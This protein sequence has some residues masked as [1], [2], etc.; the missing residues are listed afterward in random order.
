MPAELSFRSPFDWP[1]LLAFFRYRAIIGVEEVTDTSYRRTV[2]LC[3]GEQKISGWLCA[4]MAP[5][6][7]ALH[8]EWSPSLAPARAEIIQRVRQLFDLDA[9]PA[10]VQA[11]LGKLAQPFPG[12][13][14]PGAFDGMETTVR[15]ILGQQVT[16]AAASTLAGRVAT[17]LGT[18]IATP[19]PALTQVF[20][21]TT[22]LAIATEDE[23]G[24][25]GIVR[26]RV[27]AIKALAQGSLAGDVLLAPHEDVTAT[28][29][30]LKAVRGIGDWTAHYLAMR[31]LG[32]RDAFP[33]ADYGVMKALGVTTPK[34]AQTRAEAWRPYRAYAVMCLW[35]ALAEGR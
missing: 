25:L 1:R 6:G 31:V 21:V 2:E 11:V 12:V 14:V 27:A 22:R 8:L 16:V 33:A 18:P 13:R 20:P 10:Q 23:L 5:S 3:Q 4:E 15:A 35:Q 24:R 28:L 32:W 17:A 9:D 34:A 7:K 30:A 19:F 29:K 26:T